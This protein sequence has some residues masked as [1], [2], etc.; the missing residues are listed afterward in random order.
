MATSNTKGVLMYACNTANINYLTIACLNVS[1]IRSNMGDI[2]ITIVTDQNSID[3]LCDISKGVIDSADIVLTSSSDIGNEM[4]YVNN[5]DSTW[6]ETSPYDETI[7]IDPDY[8][9]LNDT[10][11]TLWGI[12][13]DMAVID[14]T[15]HV[16]SST[17]T[18]AYVN[19]KRDLKLIWGAAVYFKKTAFTKHFFNT[20]RIVTANYEYAR[21]SFQIEGTCYRRDHMLSITHHIVTCGVT[22]MP[23]TGEII[24]SPFPLVVSNAINEVLD[25][26]DT[27]KVLLKLADKDTGIY[28]MLCSCNV[29]PMNKID[30]SRKAPF[31]ISRILK[32]V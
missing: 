8:L 1:L 24:S 31:L 19:H 29:L 18:T 20:M 11:N 21:R 10:L 17:P 6:L 5:D 26:Q 28:P 16:D 23:E 14:E 25:I 13:S 27:S 15:M 3:S 2:P 9:I 22:H 7:V 12:N 4:Q 30:L 32:H